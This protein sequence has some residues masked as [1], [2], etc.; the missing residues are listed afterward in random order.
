MEGIKCVDHVQTQVFV[1]KPRIYVMSPTSA[2]EDMIHRIETCTRLL[3]KS[4]GYYRPSF[5]R[6]YNFFYWQS[7]DPSEEIVITMKALAVQFLVAISPLERILLSKLGR[8][9][10]WKEDNLNRWLKQSYHPLIQA[11]STEVIVK[12]FES[13]SV[14]SSNVIQFLFLDDIYPSLQIR[15]TKLQIQSSS[16]STDIRGNVESIRG[17]PKQM[18]LQLV[19]DLFP[20]CSVKLTQ[21][22]PK[23]PITAQFQIE[24]V[25]VSIYNPIISPIRIRS[26]HSII[27]YTT[28]SSSSSYLIALAFLCSKKVH[29]F[30][31]LIFNMEK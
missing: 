22:Q 5:P 13:S 9:L 2:I 21:S 15:G 6:F 1:E 19:S 10:E 24:V 3:Q 31:W 18:K 25:N 8:I 20:K 28:T 4:T 17:C 12:S 16:S 29:Y 11:Q 7:P 27:H 23:Q 26:S 30:S 14:V